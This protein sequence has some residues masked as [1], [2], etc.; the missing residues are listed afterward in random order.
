MLQQLNTEIRICRPKL[1]GE[2]SFK[3]WCCIEIMSPPA[4]SQLISPLTL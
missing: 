3:F 1:F 4:Y 2:G